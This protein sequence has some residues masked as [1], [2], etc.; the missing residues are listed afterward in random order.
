MS[1]I[2]LYNAFGDKAALYRRALTRYSAQTQD[3]FGS[4]AFR[5]GGVEAIA[6]LFRNSGR[7]RAASAPEHS[8][9]LMLNSL[10]DMDMIGDAAT[11]EI[12]LTRQAMV[13]GFE[14]NLRHALASGALAPVSDEVL[15]DRA[16]L[17]LSA[18][19]GGRM[20]GRLARDA[21]QASGMARGV[22]ELLEL[23]RA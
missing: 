2:S 20:S 21:S 14:A 22:C 18:L 19:W 17:L 13:E 6:A 23:W 4:E 9:C 5:R 12:V 10:I 3:Y 8:G 16:E 11:G 15:C 1:R 7:A